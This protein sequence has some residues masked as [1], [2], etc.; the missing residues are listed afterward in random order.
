MSEN[1]EKQLSEAEISEEIRN[2]TQNVEKMTRI[3]N[4]LLKVLLSKEMTEE[5]KNKEL[6][7]IQEIL[8]SNQE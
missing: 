2:I 7:S 8:K 6:M 4:R 3:Q 1:I 5:E